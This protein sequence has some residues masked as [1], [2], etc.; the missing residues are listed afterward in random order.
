MKWLRDIAALSMAAAC[1]A[2]LSSSCAGQ[3]AMGDEGGPVVEAPAGGLQ[4]RRE[5]ALNVFKG[6]PYAEAPVGERRWRPPVSAAR[7]DGVRQARDYG[8]ACPQPVARGE[9]NIYASDIGAQSEDCLSLNIWAPADAHAAPVI[10]WIHGGALTTGST[11]ETLYDGARLAAEGVIVVSINYRL[12]ILGYLAHPELS[13]ESPDHISG[14]YGLMDQIEALHWVQRNIA[15]FGGDPSNVTIAGE[16]AGGLS[17]MFLMASPP[18]RGLFA[19]AISQSGY[20]VT[21][22]E[23]NRASNGGGS[24][25]QVGAAVA[26]A[27]NAP[28]LAALRAMDATAIVNAAPGTGYFPFGTVDGRYLTAQMVET[29]ERGEQARVPI[30]AGFNDGEIRSLP[31]LIPPPPASAAQYERAIR[32]RY[33]DLSDAFLRLYPTTNVRESMLATTRDALYGWTAE[34]LV[35]NQTAVGQPGYLYLWDHGYGAADVLGLHA[36]HASELPYMWGNLERTP[37]RW[38][39][40]PRNARER[41]LSAAMVQYWTSF[42]RTGVPQAANAPAWPAYGAGEAFMHFRDNGPHASARLY[43]GAMFRLH[44]EAVCRRRATGAQPWNWNVGVISPP[45]AVEHAPCAAP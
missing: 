35:R 45:L 21:M 7:W 6:V 16:S 29:F 13:A 11:K 23:L 2:A 26:R 39:A 3:T 8:P 30:L 1:F 17:V 5:G 41:A 37:P 34:R 38:P 33:A 28:N 24:A 12:G 22:L 42:A 31:F 14:N 18:A 9:N 10:V 40:V 19:K 32:E 4:G 44:E 27:L 25:E 20:M 43:G 36:F 15:A